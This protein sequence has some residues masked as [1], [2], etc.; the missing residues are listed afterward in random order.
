MIGNN[1]LRSR[2]FTITAFFQ[3]HDFDAQGTFLDK[4]IFNFCDE[5]LSSNFQRSV[6]RSSTLL[7]INKVKIFS[8]RFK[9]F[10][11]PI[12]LLRFR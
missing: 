6:S 3:D 8:D 9:I 5:L 7:K 12:R 10:S 2:G 4:V 11:I 1:F